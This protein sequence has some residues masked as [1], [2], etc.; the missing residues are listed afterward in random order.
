[1]SLAGKLGY[2]YSQILNFKLTPTHSTQ[3]MLHDWATG[4]DAT[5]RKLYETLKYD[6]RRDDAAMVLDPHVQAAVKE[7]LIF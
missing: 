7:T 5:V 1:M 6:L 2:T 4:P 3:M